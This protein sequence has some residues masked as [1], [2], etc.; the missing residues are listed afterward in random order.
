MRVIE[1]SAQPEEDNALFDAW[2]ELH[3]TEHADGASDSTPAGDSR[4][5]SAAETI[6][7][8]PYDFSPARL[9]CME[10]AVQLGAAA[11]PTQG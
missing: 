10:L 8:M 3:P 5:T 1:E 2:D 7:K 11:A 6:R 4:V 9:R